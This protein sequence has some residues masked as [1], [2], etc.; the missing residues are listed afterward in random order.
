[1]LIPTDILRDRLL[2]KVHEVLWYLSDVFQAVFPRER[3]KEY[4]VL[5][6]MSKFSHTCSLLQV[7]CIFHSL[8]HPPK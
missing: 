2:C 7:S 3:V 8:E 6:D 4:K 5:H 1:M